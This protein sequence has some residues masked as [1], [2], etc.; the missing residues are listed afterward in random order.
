MTDKTKQDQLDEML[1]TW[2]TESLHKNTPCTIINDYAAKKYT[3]FQF[4]LIH[5]NDGYLDANFQYEL[6]LDDFKSVGEGNSKQIAKQ[7]ASLKMIEKILGSK[8]QLLLNQF[9]KSDSYAHMVYLCASKNTKPVGDPV[10]ELIKFCRSNYL[11]YPEFTLV[12]EEGQS[13]AKKFTVSCRVGKI[14]EK[15]TNVS[16]K[17]SK[18]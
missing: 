17:I 7:A 18:M 9:Q 3:T 11:S 15:A 13:H 16:K 6:T 4:S 12:Y 1:F 5:H 10:G 8:S 14:S 2:F